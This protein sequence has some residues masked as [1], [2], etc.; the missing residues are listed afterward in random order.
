MGSYMQKKWPFKNVRN[1]KVKLCFKNHAFFRQK[2]EILVSMHTRGQFKVTRGLRT[3]TA[4]FGKIGKNHFS[5]LYKGL[6]LLI[7]V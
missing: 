6:K 4:C 7:P 2:V 3:N 1:F 5:Y